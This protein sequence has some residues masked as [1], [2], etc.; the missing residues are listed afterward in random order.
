MTTVSTNFLY[1]GR[2]SGGRQSHLRVHEGNSGIFVELNALLFLV[3]AGCA[4]AV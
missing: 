4:A 3:G 2:S 1:Y